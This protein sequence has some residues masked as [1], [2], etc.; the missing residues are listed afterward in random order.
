MATPGQRVGSSY[1]HK[2]GGYPDLWRL[3]CIG[4]LCKRNAL[5][6]LAVT[7]IKSLWPGDPSQSRVRLSPIQHL[8]W[9]LKDRDQLRRW[10][11]V[12]EYEAPRGTLR[13]ALN[14]G[15]SPSEDSISCVH[16]AIIF[17][18]LTVLDELGY[19]AN[20][21][22]IDQILGLFIRDR[23]HTFVRSP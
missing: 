12:V 5:L 1:C 9:R 3:L 21:H 23:S 22:A 18:G 13:R 7:M 2:P 10:R 14:H 11:P 20:F 15:R 19:A 16:S 6:W 4:V 8:S 17:P